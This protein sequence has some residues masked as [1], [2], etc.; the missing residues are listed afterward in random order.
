MK[1]L[2]FASQA[3]KALPSRYI[4]EVNHVHCLYVRLIL[5]IR[6]DGRRRLRFSLKALRIYNRLDACVTQ[7]DQAQSSWTKPRAV[8]PSP[9]QLVPPRVLAAPR[10]RYLLSERR[11]HENNENAGMIHRAVQAE[12]AI[13]S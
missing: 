8:G 11:H 2:I 6:V 5:G 1:A 13:V 4:N 10:I 9:E 3:A 7:L 12:S